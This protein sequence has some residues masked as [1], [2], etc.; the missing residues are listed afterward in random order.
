M[1]VDRLFDKL[2]S[3]EEALTAAVAASALA[4]S[5]SPSS[6]QTNEPST[7]TRGFGRIT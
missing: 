7:S 6:S 5:G 1:V 3:G 4:K 2:A